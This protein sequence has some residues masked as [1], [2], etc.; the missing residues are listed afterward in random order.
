MKTKRHALIAGFLAVLV[1]ASGATV[2]AQE[3]DSDRGQAMTRFTQGVMLLEQGFADRAV[4]PL[5]E[6][7]KLSRHDPAIGERLAQAYYAT[8]D[9]SRADMIAGL[10]LEANPSSLSML[11]MKSRLCLA[12]GD[13]RGAIVFLERARGAAPASIE[14][15]RMLATL[16]AENGDAEQAIASLER[17]IRLEPDIPDLRVALGE[18]FLSAGRNDEAETAFR[19]ALAIDGTDP[20]A[21]ENLVNLYQSQQRKAEA[22]AVLEA[23]VETPGATAAARLQLAQAYA[24]AGRTDEAVRLL[25]AARKQGESSEEAD[26]LLGRVYFE[27]RRFDDARRVF[28]ALYKK[29]NAS[30][31]LARILGDLSLKTGDAAGARTYFDRAIELNPEDYRSYLALFFAQ[32]ERFTKDGARIVMAPRDAAALLAKAAGKSPRADVDAQFSLG[33]AYSSIDSLEPACEHLSRASELEPERQDVLFNLASVYEKMLRYDDAERVLIDLYELA[34]DDAAVCNFYGYLLALMRKD[35]DRAE[36][37]VRHALEKEPDNAYFVDSLG[38]VYFQRGEYARAVTE[39][40]RAVRLVG[41]DPVMLE[42][43]G[44]AY[45]ELSRFKDALAVYQHSSQLQESNSKLRE[46]IESMQRRLH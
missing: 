32:S 38:W 4:G 11:H 25:E 41:E 27:A 37:L 46:K 35:L 28:L 36:R 30:P 6:A 22:I 19:D 18:M 15:E 3:G 39:L 24:D 17:C 21:V 42:H 23:Y 31:E 29:T 9:V 33:M 45:S 34:P 43:L 12:R 14:T 16:Y 1:L 7:W 10:V 20:A 2:S 5:N 40:E 26:L 13:T 44:D 8:R